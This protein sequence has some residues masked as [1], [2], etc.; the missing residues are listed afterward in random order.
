MT[1]LASCST[2]LT[3]RDVASAPSSQIKYLRFDQ[4]KDRSDD[5]APIVVGHAWKGLEGIKVDAAFNLN[6]EGREKIHFFS[7]NKYY[8]YDFQF[9]RLD[10]GYPVS[11]ATAW[12]GLG[13][14]KVDAAFAKP[15]GLVYFFKDNY[16]YKYDLSR[17]KLDS[18]RSLLIKDSWHG[19]DFNR[20]D[21]T[22]KRDN[23]VYF[24]SNGY[25]QKF[26]LDKDKALFKMRKVNEFSW[27]GVWPSG[28]GAAFY[29]QS[30]KKYYFFKNN[31]KD[32]IVKNH[33]VIL[34]TLDGLRQ[35]EFFN[36][37]SDQSKARGRKFFPYLWNNIAPNG[38]VLGD[39]RQS[40]SFT[41]ANTSGVSLP[42]YLSIFSGLFI[43][44]CAGNEGY[45]F[46]CPRGNVVSTFVDRLR[47][48]LKLGKKEVGVFA[49]WKRIEDAIT[50]DKIYPPS[51]KAFESEYYRTGYKLTEGRKFNKKFYQQEVD[52]QRHRLITVNTGTY[53]Y[54][55]AG[56]P[57]AHERI[58]DRYRWII[59]NP[60]SEN[61]VRAD[62]H[63]FAHAM[64]FL[65]HNK[66]KFLYIY[67]LDTD[68][69]GHADEYEKYMDGIDAY[70]RYIKEIVDTLKG[71]G[72]YGEN[73]SLVITTDHSRGL[74]SEWTNHG[75]PYMKTKTSA[76]NIKNIWAVIYGPSTRGQGSLKN[77]RYS[78]IHLRP[79]I[80]KLLG[81]QP[82]LGDENIIKEAF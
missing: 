81:L 54:V 50:K 68:A 61:N 40:S 24:F 28:P 56:N 52:R 62:T 23:F 63:T 53:A 42:G 33:N 22:V 72:E 26:D 45:E 47:D 16:Y 76:E 44:E 7:D 48:E 5:G 67:L 25:Y 74:S 77:T 6:I 37:V 12:P 78:H 60:S 71:M 11:I 19:L 20:V 17:A 34:L 2:T 59:D 79:T 55:D 31:V 57:G 13:I 21:A 66:P 18:N 80:E 43:S 70:D 4:S 15:N 1:L 46:S 14:S 51:L 73:T 3:A 29:R 65:K 35:N 58:N 69:H 64:T 9:D 30:N 8:R 38:I 82:V 41:I 27:S 32:V 75:I 36:Q 39:P 49:S 10:P